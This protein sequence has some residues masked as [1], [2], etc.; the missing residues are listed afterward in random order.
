MLNVVCVLRKSDTYTEVWA[1]RLQA[2]V[3]RFLSMEHR[4]VCFSDVQPDCEVVI[5]LRDDYPGW[6]SKMEIMRPGLTGSVLFFDL[7]TLILGDLTSIASVGRLTML[8]DFY[9]EG[10]C[11]SGVMFLP[12]EDRRLVWK[13]WIS[14]V[15]ENVI[16]SFRGDQEYL[17]TILHNKACFWQQKCPSQI[18]SYKIHCQDGKPKNA[19]VLCFHGTPKQHELN[20]WTREFWHRDIFSYEPDRVCVVGNG[21]FQ[22]DGA[23]DSYD[24]VVRFNNFTID[25]FNVGSKV[26]HWV[27]SFFTDVE[28]RSPECWDFEQVVVPL[29]VCDGGYKFRKSF[30]DEWGFRVKIC[31]K[32][33]FRK[34]RRTLDNPSTGM[35]FLLWYYMHHGRLPGKVVGFT[36]FDQSKPTHYFSPYRKQTGHNGKNEKKVFE[37][38]DSK[39]LVFEGYNETMHSK[40]EKIAYLIVSETGE[41]PYDIPDGS[42]VYLAKWTEGNPHKDNVLYMPDN[43]WSD[44]RNELYDHAR[45]Q[46]DYLYYVYMDDDAGLVNFTLEDFEKALR[47]DGLTKPRL[48]FPKLIGHY[49]YD[50]VPD[51]ETNILYFDHPIVAIRGDIANQMP[52]SKEFDDSCWWRTTTEWCERYYENFGLTG[53]CFGWMHMENL[54]HRTSYPRV[55]GV[56][57]EQK[58]L[59]PELNKKNRETLA[60]QYHVR[61]DA[62]QAEEDWEN[63]AA[64]WTKGAKNGG[65]QCVRNLI[66][67]Y[68]HVKPS[69]PMMEYWRR[70]AY[71]EGI[72]V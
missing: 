60:V 57:Y 52:F 15:P 19:R 13:R 35:A 47:R 12:E 63:A 44:S 30:M 65:E 29:P 36:F 20:N 61:G 67:L 41:C 51:E 68:T 23:I 69:N 25:G 17:H 3:R 59:L 24:A 27:T 31:D 4:F 18:V 43:I 50:V 54:Q 64:M 8:E 28:N 33:S 7:D 1:E 62:Y 26:T 39:E 38:M 16:R 10:Q 72:S 48:A 6:W 40:P 9:L 34:I 58:F 55:E 2:A 21:P 37:L 71:L 46:H 32:E 42:D 53:I 14:E 22:D 49:F 70:F 5:P 66:W 56:I 45:S 11:A